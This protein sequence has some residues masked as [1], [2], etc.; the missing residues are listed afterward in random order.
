[1]Q[2]KEM[3]LKAVAQGKIKLVKLLM[4]GGVDVN[5]QGYDGKT[6][7]IVACSFVARNKNSDSESL[8]NLINLLIKGGANTNAHDMKGRTPLMYAVR[9]FLSTDIIKLLLDNGANPTMLDNNGRNTLHYIKRKCL[10]F[11]RCIFQRY[12]GPE[13][14]SHDLQIFNNCPHNS[15]NKLIFSQSTFN[16]E[17]NIFRRASDSTDTCRQNK[18]KLP[19]R[20]CNSY[21]NQ[22]FI[23]NKSI[24]KENECDKQALRP[25]EKCSIAEGDKKSGKDDIR[26]I[27]MNEYTLKKNNESDTLPSNAA[28]SKIYQ[29]DKM[30]DNNRKTTVDNLTCKRVLKS[31]FRSSGNVWQGI[32]KLENKMMQ[33]GM[34]N[35]P[36]K[37][38]PIF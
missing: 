4:D 30:E 29:S 31:S 38:P 20:K 10:P 36:V 6:P 12:L 19:K 24:N 35:V 25:Y 28:S 33:T 15:T 22:S 17:D 34:T 16:M 37:L 8:M 26:I 3:L 13:L 9:H 23:I 14:S 21:S 18:L 11:Y 7:L 27:Q 32:S 5:F 1:Y 2:E